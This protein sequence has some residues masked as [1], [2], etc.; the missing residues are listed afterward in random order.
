MI[1]NDEDNGQWMVVAECDRCIGETTQGWGW[2]ITNLRWSMKSRGPCKHLKRLSLSIARGSG[3]GVT[4]KDNACPGNCSVP[5]SGMFMRAMWQPW[6]R[7]RGSLRC[8]MVTS[9]R[10]PWL[11]QNGRTLK[12]WCK[13]KKSVAKITFYMVVF[14]A[15]GGE[16]IAKGPRISFWLT[17]IF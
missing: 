7:R 3:P 2:L 8:G 11:L 17:K 6:L 16:R 14:M 15:E 4:Y 1:S 13:W 10:H 12:T 5:T 9:S